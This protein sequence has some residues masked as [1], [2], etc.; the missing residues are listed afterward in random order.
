MKNVTLSF[1]K[2]ASL[3]SKINLYFVI[4]VYVM[5]KK[6]KKNG[7][8]VTVHIGSGMCFMS[9]SLNTLNDVIFFPIYDCK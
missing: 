3:L 9:C 6:K 4:F 8:L 5:K 1:L 2:K 7:Y